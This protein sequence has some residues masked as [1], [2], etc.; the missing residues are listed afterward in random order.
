MGKGPILEH[1]QDVC[2]IQTLKQST[3]ATEGSGRLG[4][5]GPI[6]EHNKDV[7]QIQQLKQL[8][9]ATDGTV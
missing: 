7:Y 2:V 3:L 8:T 6:L 9:L 5:E 1:Y 4:V